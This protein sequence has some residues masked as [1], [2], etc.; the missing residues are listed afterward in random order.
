MHL[1]TMTAAREDYLSEF[2]FWDL[3]A[4]GK[5]VRAL[6]QLLTRVTRWVCE[7]FA[8]NEAQPVLSK[9]ITLLLPRGKVAKKL[10]YFCH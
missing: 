3:K 7:K 9:I 4:K 6:H 2:D 8:Q 5:I 1:F 10:G